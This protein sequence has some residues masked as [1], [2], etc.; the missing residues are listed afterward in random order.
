M[1]QKTFYCFL[2][3]MVL[4]FAI[5]AVKNKS[6]ELSKEQ[7]QEAVATV[8]N[9]ILEENSIQ[10]NNELVNCLG[11]SL[12]PVY[13]FLDEGLNDP[14]EMFTDLDKA[15]EKISGFMGFLSYCIV[16]TSEGQNLQKAYNLRADI[17]IEEV[18]DVVLKYVVLHPIDLN[19]YLDDAEDEWDDQNYKEVGHIFAK[20]GH[21]IVDG[22]DLQIQSQELLIQQ[23]KNTKKGISKRKIKS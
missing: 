16:Y 13:D 9:G 23:S 8:I 20:M 5:N 4:P 1:R 6:D 3:L 2:L 7:K 21:A 19:G 15:L 22:T 18:R 10:S 17:L 12:A 14:F 11:D